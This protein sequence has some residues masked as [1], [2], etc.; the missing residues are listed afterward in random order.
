[1]KSG[2]K[3]YDSVA[4]VPE[5]V[6]KTSNDSFTPWWLW[7]GWPPAGRDLGMALWWFGSRDGV[8]N[9]FKS[10]NSVA[11]ALQKQPF[12]IYILQ[13]SRSTAQADVM[14]I[15]YTQELGLGLGPAQF[16]EPGPMARAQFLCVQYY[17]P[18]R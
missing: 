9:G 8:K 15:L 7:A 12:S 5:K 10:L 14:L 4:E 1:M 13:N 6:K 17:S 11:D 18:R 3:T 2:L 16:L